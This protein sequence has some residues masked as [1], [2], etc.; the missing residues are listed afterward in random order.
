MRKIRRKSLQQDLFGAP[1]RARSC[2]REV[3]SSSIDGTV[4][5]SEVRC[6][7]VL[8]RSGIPVIDYAV[9]PYV[10]CTHA[11]VYCY[12]IFMRRFALHPE[13]WGSFLDV[14]INAP[15]V[16]ERQ[17]GRAARGRVTVGTVTD[18]YQ[19]GERRF[20]VTRG[21][22]EVLAA[23]TFPISLLTKSPLVVR[24]IDVIGRIPDA[25]VGLTIT[26]LDDEVRG[27]FEPGSPP[28]EARLRALRQLADAGVRTWAFCGP[29]LPC[30]SD[31][32]GHL[33]R[34]FQRLAAGGVRSVVV[35]SLNLR[36]VIWPRVRSVLAAHY[37]DLLPTY[38]RLREC[39]GPYHAELMAAAR[40]LAARHGLQC[41]S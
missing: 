9:N 21:C 12:A 31:D 13:E 30:L 37:P 40:G 25:E 41:P 15:E 7:S 39:R 16:L 27:R 8:N 1:V 33:D 20:R 2:R 3:V 11:C 28:V 17:L 5:V 18:P 32:R 29:L 14:K 19:P 36:G 6:S 26:T 23:S 34:L 38:R 24:D 22:L 35:D 10:G 4:V